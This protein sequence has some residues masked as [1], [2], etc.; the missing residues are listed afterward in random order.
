MFCDYTILAGWRFFLSSFLFSFLPLDLRHTQT[1]IPHDV[2]DFATLQSCTLLCALAQKR[3]IVEIPIC[4]FFC[5]PG[6]VQR[7]GHWFMTTPSLGNLAQPGIA[8][9]IQ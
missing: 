5:I 9:K 2:H 6:L 7:R 1:Y 4:F 3:R 8:Y